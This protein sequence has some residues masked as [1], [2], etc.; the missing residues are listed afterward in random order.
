MGR[1]SLTGAV[2]AAAV[3]VMFLT[4]PVFAQGSSGNSSLASI[5][6]LCHVT[7]NGPFRTI[8][9][10]PSGAVVRTQPFSEQ[11]S[12]GPMLR[13]VRSTYARF[14]SPGSLV[15]SLSLPEP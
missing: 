3:G 2:L 12:S 15:P 6:E 4:T 9:Q 10:S 11:L 1:K 7:E 8:S 13:S 14:R 5:H